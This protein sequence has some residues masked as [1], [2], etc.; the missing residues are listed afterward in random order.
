MEATP[1][2]STN[3]LFYKAYPSGDGAVEK[4]WILV[5]RE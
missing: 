3:P 1:T 4:M 5:D 2:T